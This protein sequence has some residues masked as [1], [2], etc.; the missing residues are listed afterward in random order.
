MLLE[1]SLGLSG[2]SNQGLSFLITISVLTMLYRS[3]STPRVSVLVA[4]EDTW[5]IATASTHR[6]T[7]NCLPVEGELILMRNAGAPIVWV[8]LGAME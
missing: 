8:V 1:S 6:R 4:Q 5:R 2:F 3:G 7:T